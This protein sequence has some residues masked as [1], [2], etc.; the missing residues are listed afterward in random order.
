M[1]LVK[2]TLYR[3]VL[4][5]F[6][7]AVLYLLGMGGWLLWVAAVFIAFLLSYIALPRPRAAA[8]QY[9]LE[10]RNRRQAGHRFSDTQEED[11]ADED[12]QIESQQI[13]DGG[14]LAVNPD[15]GDAL[16]DCGD[17][18]GLAVHPD[19]GDRGDSTDASDGL[20]RP[21]N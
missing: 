17:G 15:G 4:F 1:P 7:A 10:R 16:P 14:G 8:S 21:K 19:G 6:A 20:P 13:R 11:F 5:L 9:L 12:T 3:V 2:Y 18:G